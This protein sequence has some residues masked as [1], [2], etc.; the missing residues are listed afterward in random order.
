MTCPSCLGAPWTLGPKGGA[1]CDMAGTEGVNLDCLASCGKT[2]AP[3]GCLLGGNRGGDLVLIQPR[4]PWGSPSPTPSHPHPVLNACPN[5]R[6]CQYLHRAQATESSAHTTASPAS[7]MAAPSVFLRAC[8][9]L[10]PSQPHS[11]SGEDDLSGPS[12][13]R[14]TTEQLFRSLTVEFLHEACGYRALTGTA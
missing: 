4:L 7:L 8:S 11:S 10:Q 12:W 5:P 9:S 1:W 6:S 14:Y 13:D 2:L 3:P